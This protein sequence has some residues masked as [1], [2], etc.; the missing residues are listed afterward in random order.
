MDIS[1]KRILKDLKDLEK[2]LN[3]HKFIIMYIMMIFIILKF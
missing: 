3:S 2:D 1:V